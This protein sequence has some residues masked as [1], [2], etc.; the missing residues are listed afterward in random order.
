[1]VLFERERDGQRDRSAEGAMLLPVQG[2]GGGGGCCCLMH[3]VLLC[4]NKTR[5]HV[6]NDTDDVDVVPADTF[7]DGEE[8]EGGSVLDER[9]RT[10]VPQLTVCLS[11]SALYSQRQ[12]PPNI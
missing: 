7:M 12:C 11:G 9:G 2:R 6:R 3:H 10:P 5:W 4:T 1:M 8:G